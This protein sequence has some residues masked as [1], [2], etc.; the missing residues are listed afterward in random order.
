MPQDTKKAPDVPSGETPTLQGLVATKEDEAALLDALEKAF[1]YR[2]DVTLTLTDGSRVEGYL[3]DRRRG[4]SL[5]TSVAR[6]MP[7]EGPTE[8]RAI[9]FSAI[10]RVEISGKDAAHGKS[11]E[12]WVRRFTEKKLKELGLSEEEIRERLSESEG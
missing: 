1:D 6:I 2:G 8:R 11:F 7:A 4:D 9:P 3:F 12:R 10:E 5:E